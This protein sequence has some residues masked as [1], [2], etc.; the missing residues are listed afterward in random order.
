MSSYIPMCIFPNKIILI[1][2]SLITSKVSQSCYG[3]FY[4]SQN[5]IESQIR[6]IK[7]AKNFKRTNLQ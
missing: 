6:P 1:G 2:M 5:T 3:P 4:I 7:K